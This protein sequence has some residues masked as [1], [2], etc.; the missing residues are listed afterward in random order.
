MKKKEKYVKICPRCGGTNI[1]IPPVGLDIRM[2]LKDYCN[3]CKS[4][5]MFPEIKE[6]EVEEFRKKLKGK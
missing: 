5:G 4:W 1:K 3:D 2:T 6:S